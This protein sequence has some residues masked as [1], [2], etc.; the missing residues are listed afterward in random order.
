MRTSSNPIE[1]KLGTVGKPIRSVEVRI[2]SDGEIEVSGPNVMSGYYKKEQATREAFTADGFFKTGDIGEFD[3]EGFL[4]ITDRKKELFKT[5]GGKYIAPS[6]VEQNIK[7]SRFVNQVVLVGNDRKFPA[8]L[9]VPNF[10]QLAS[11]AKREG[12]SLKT[13]KD[14]CANDK[15]IKLFEK[16]VDAATPDLSKYEKV[17]KIALL[18][19]EMTVEGGEMTPTLKIKRRVVDEKYKDVIEKIYEEK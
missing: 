11:Y 3:A 13:H 14:F 7:G 9:I 6:P 8:A 18:E 12:L 5:S 19:E 4:K 1:V 17:K 16:E 10:E 2:A 15:I